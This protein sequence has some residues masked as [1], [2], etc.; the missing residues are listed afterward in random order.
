MTFALEVP[1]AQQVRHIL[2]ISWFMIVEEKNA[3]LGSTDKMMKQKGLC[4]KNLSR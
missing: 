2:L 3:N 1:P 4:Y